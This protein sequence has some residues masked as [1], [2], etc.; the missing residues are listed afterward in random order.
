MKAF[1]NFVNGKHV[2]AADGATTAVVNPATG[3]QY[4]D[5]AAVGRRPTST[6]RWR[7]RRRRSRGGATPRPRERSLAL[8]RIA[9]AVEARAEELI[10]LEVENTRQADRT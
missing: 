9:D 5:G 2:D 3:E 1:Q 6:P 10:A 4:A 8:F 7:R